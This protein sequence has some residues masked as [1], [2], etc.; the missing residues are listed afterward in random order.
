MFLGPCSD[1]THKRMLL[2]PVV[3]KKNAFCVCATLD[4]DWRSV[5]VRG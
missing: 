5:L 3:V 4:A 2:K 1:A